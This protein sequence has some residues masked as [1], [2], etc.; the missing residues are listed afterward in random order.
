MKLKESVFSFFNEQKETIRGF[1]VS[2]LG[3]FGSTV[4]NQDEQ[5]SDVDIMV[6]FVVGQKCYDN[7]IDLCYFLEDSLGRKVDLLTPEGISPIVKQKIDK[8]IEYVQI[9]A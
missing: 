5:G 1:G 9:S 7:F 4:R 2:R 8:E 3:L 6:E